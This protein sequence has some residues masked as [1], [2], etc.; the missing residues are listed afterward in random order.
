MLYIYYSAMRKKE[1]LPSSTTR[2]NLEGIMLSEI[3]HTEKDKYW[4]I[5][6][7]WNLKKPN[8]LKQRME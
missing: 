7:M 2:M 8:L 6:H 4:M 3:R 5:S 1:I